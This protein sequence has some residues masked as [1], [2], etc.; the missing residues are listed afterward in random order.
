MS[1]TKVW[2]II[3][4]IGIITFSLRFSFIFLFGKIKIPILIQRALRFVPVTVLPALIFPQFFYQANTIN[5]SW[6]NE[7]LVAGILAAF[8]AWRTQNVPLTILVGMVGL[9]ILQG[10]K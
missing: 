2:I 10:V 4:T 1:E 5:I 6:G 9:W 7:R 8:V 3:I